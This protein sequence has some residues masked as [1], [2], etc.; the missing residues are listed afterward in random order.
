MSAETVQHYCLK[1]RDKDG[2]HLPY[3]LRGVADLLRM[4]QAGIRMGLTPEVTL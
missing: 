4:M 1:L 3:R 2:T